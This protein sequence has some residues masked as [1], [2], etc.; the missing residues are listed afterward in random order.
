[1]LVRFA[2]ALLL[3]PLLATVALADKFT[4]ATVDAALQQARALTGVTAVVT[5]RQSSNT[6]R[7]ALGRTEANPTGGSVITIYPNVFRRSGFPWLEGSNYTGPYA[8]AALCAT[9]MHE[10]MHACMG[11]QTGT[12]GSGPNS[13][14]HLAIDNACR[15]IL[16]ARAGELEELACA[17][18][19]D[20]QALAELLALCQEI[21][22]IR[23]RWNTPDNGARA[24]D[25][26]HGDGNPNFESGTGAG[27]GCPPAY[28]PDPGGGWP[29]QKDEN[30]NDMT[31]EDGNPIPDVIPACPACECVADD[32]HQQ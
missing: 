12:P 14:K 16:C 26:V 13:C 22:R 5:I 30:G 27:A 8:H 6:D 25:C 3:S 11:D 29:T 19:R 7:N 2:F 18:E 31:D 9:L 4:Q 20:E 1:M 15:N 23:A 10:L 21:A 17:E 28:P 32:I 24:L